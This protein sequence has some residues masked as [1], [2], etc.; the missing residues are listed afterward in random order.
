[1]RRLACCSVRSLILAVALAGLIASPAIAAPIV[2]LFD[3]G[4]AHVTATRSSDSSVVMDETI[5]LNGVFVRFDP[6]TPEISDFAITAPMSGAIS[7]LQPWGGFDTIVIE[8]S[9]IVPSVACSSIFTSMI[10]PTTYSF[11]VGPVDVNG[12]YSAYS[13]GGPPPLPVSNV[14]VPFIGSSFLNGT[15]DTD[16]IQL[17]LLG[18]TSHRGSGSGLRRDRQPGDQGRHHLVR[19]GS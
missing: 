17:D 11:L 3:S 18:N 4:S 9:S 16:L 5:P 10:G 1:M 19:L 8:S 2:Y 6:V 14:P 7:L 12:V 15:I 13:S